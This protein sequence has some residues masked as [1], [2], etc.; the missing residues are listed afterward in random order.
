MPNDNNL[1]PLPVIPVPEVELQEPGQFTFF[2]NL[3]NLVNIPRNWSVSYDR[4]RD[5][6]PSTPTYQLVISSGVGTA[7]E[8]YIRGVATFR[9]EMS[10]I[11]DL[12]AITRNIVTGNAAPAKSEIYGGKIEDVS[13]NN[14]YKYINQVGDGANNLFSDFTQGAFNAVLGEANNSQ[15]PES[16]AVREITTVQS[17][18]PQNQTT[19]ITATK[20]TNSS[21]GKSSVS[22][23]S[24]NYSKEQLTN[25][26]K[27]LIKTE[28]SDLIGSNIK[29]E[30]SDGTINAELL[31]NSLLSEAEKFL[32]KNTKLDSPILTETDSKGNPLYLVKSDDDLTLSDGSKTNLNTLVNTITSAQTHLSHFMDS[33]FKESTAIFTT[34]EG[35]AGMISDVSAGIQRGDSAE[36]I[37]GVI[38][39]K[40]AIRTLA[41][42]VQNELLF[43]EA[44]EQLIE[45]GDFTNLSTEGQETLQ[46]IQ[47][48]PY[49]KT[50]YTAAIAFATSV[51]LNANE[52]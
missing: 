4:L 8:T 11:D 15:N 2:S 37:A 33:F 6:N 14:V 34:P 38:A 20:T 52:D 46:M 9:A 48:N 42:E 21:T 36:Q 18:N 16:K 7:A 31:N 24:N 10:R 44:D 43:S 45:S 40:A 13:G 51:L 32:A 39:T 26:S 23:S 41:N 12:F 29:I 27:S 1:P 5:S 22:V 35:V 17:T 30:G 47:T 19:T 49:Y 50:A 3:E 25:S 28:G